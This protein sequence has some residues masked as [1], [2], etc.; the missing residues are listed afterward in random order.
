VKSLISDQR[1]NS[2]SRKAGR[3]LV[4]YSFRFS[5]FYIFHNAF[6]PVLNCGAKTLFLFCTVRFE[7]LVAKIAD[8]YFDFV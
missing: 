3:I 8:F 1:V 4:T 6:L 5:H 2:V 7:A